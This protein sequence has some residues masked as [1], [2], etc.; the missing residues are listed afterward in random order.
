M[1]KIYSAIALS[2]LTIGCVAGSGRVETGTRS[3]GVEVACE[4]PPDDDV[5]VCNPEPGQDDPSMD[6]PAD[7]GAP[8]TDTCEGRSGALVLWPPN[9]KLHTIDV[10]D[11]A[12]L[13]YCDDD[14]SFDPSI[15]HIVAVTS[16]EPVDV[17]GGGDGHT[18]KFDM[19]IVD[20]RTVELRSERQGKGDG[21]VY[22]ALLA[23]DDGDLAAC[24]VHVPHNQG[25]VVGAVD[26]GEA[27]RIDG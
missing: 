26:S 8:P 19:A 17:G 13:T 5:W 7:E 15:W 4:A 23:S 27:E 21:R 6:P 9:H 3:D 20:A 18:D 2:S 12:A 25:P 10:L 16:D 24:E 11:C 14:M 1:T 22:R